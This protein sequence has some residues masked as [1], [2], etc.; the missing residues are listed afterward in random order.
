MYY[1]CKVPWV[2]LLFPER[3]VM[4]VRASY[5]NDGATRYE[6]V[7]S[8]LN[9]MSVSRFEKIVAASGLAMEQ[10]TYSCVRGINWLG[11]VPV[12]RELFTNNVS[13]VLRHA[14]A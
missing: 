5:R 13:C 2:N 10:R 14:V 4:K 1:F 6:E 9:R 11:T 12:A 3:T 8:G 7:E